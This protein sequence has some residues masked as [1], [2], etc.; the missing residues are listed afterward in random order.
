M[1]FVATIQLGSLVTNTTALVET[2]QAQNL[3]VTN[4]TVQQLLQSNV[5]ASTVSQL[6]CHYLTAV[7]SREKFSGDTVLT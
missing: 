3:S 2:I 5:T 1:S 6:E 4:A 7:T